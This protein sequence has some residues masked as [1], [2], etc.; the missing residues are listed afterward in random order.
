MASRVPITTLTTTTDQPDLL[1]EDPDHTRWCQSSSIHLATNFH[2]VAFVVGLV[3]PAEGGR[4]SSS[5][6]AVIKT[7]S[8]ERQPQ[9]L[10]DRHTDSFLLCHILPVWSHGVSQIRHH[11]LKRLSVTG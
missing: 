3:V 2:K 5:A 10:A 9:S 8:A 4:G 11:F 7:V 6:K 1:V